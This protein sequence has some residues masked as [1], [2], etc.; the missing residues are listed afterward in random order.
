LVA[1]EESE[2]A[3][4]RLLVEHVKFAP[5]VMHD[6]MNF[7]KKGLLQIVEDTARPR[8]RPTS[9]FRICAKFGRILSWFDGNLFCLAKDDAQAY[10]TMVIRHSV[11]FGVIEVTDNDKLSRFKFI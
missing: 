1:L 8:S 11:W 7:S 10:V 5:H 4:N 6:V 3:A 9:T 2:V